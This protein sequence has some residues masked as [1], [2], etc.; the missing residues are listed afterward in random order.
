MTVA[1]VALLPWGRT[2]YALVAAVPVQPGRDEAARLAREELAKSVYRDAQPSLVER[3]LT[4]GY[5]LVQRLLDSVAGASPGGIGG[6]AVALLV[7]VAL[8]IALRLK[9]GPLARTATRDLAL[10]T[11][12]TRS[13]ADHRRAADGHAAS[14]AWDLA[15]RERFR[16]VVRGLEERAVLEERPGRTAAEAA[17]HAGAV[18]PAYA[19]DLAAAARLFDDVTYGGRPAGPESDVRVRVLDERISS[20]RSQPSATPAGTS[21]APR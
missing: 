5:H 13:A 9:V 20:A 16:A 10:F 4:W 3:F 15:V 7:V 11:D 18:L 8:L 21:T 2:G 14:G 6:V 17:R 1:A 19:G 12:R